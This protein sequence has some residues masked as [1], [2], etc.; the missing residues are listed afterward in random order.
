MQ[1]GV[2]VSYA[3]WR[4][5]G[6]CFPDGF[7][8][9]W[10]WLAK[11][12]TGKPL[13]MTGGDCQDT[14]IPFSL[15]TASEDMGMLTGAVAWK[16]T[17]VC[18]W[19]SQADE[20]IGLAAEERTWLRNSVLEFCPGILPQKSGLEFCFGIFA[21]VFCLRMLLSLFKLPKVTQY[22]GLGLHTYNVLTLSASAHT[23]T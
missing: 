5:V 19:D 3:V 9:R 20:C 12:L 17:G 16:N 1:Y 10:W 8:W 11:L 22:K 15:S 4:V 23:H 18:R 13:K 6:W 7:R 2:G 14:L 21:L